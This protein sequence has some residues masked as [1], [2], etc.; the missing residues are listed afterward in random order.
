MLHPSVSLQ[1]ILPLYVFICL[2][3][4]DAVD[5]ALC[6]WDSVWSVCVI[7][8]LTTMLSWW[9]WRW[10][11]LVSHPSPWLDRWHY[12]SGIQEEK[13]CSS[14]CCSSPPLRF[15][16]IEK[17]LQNSLAPDGHPVLCYWVCNPFFRSLSQSPPPPQNEIQPGTLTHACYFNYS[18][19]MFFFFFLLLFW[20]ATSLAT[21]CS[22]S[23]CC[24]LLIKG[25]GWGDRSRI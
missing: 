6:K 1:C 9:P 13:F 3:D 20:F 2:H 17:H 19:P 25:C 22:N 14:D 18:F 21:L 15:T 23:A 10:S 7:V 24:L 8:R 5:T 12:H 16:L 11:C 4:N